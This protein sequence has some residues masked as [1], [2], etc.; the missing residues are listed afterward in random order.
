MLGFLLRILVAIFTFRI[1][2][3]LVRV[4]GYLAG[5]QSGRP[6]LEPP[7]AAPPEPLVDR[8]SAID[9]PFTEERTEP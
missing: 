9:V 6:P 2:F 8:A 3:A 5:R 1:L 4:V 7:R